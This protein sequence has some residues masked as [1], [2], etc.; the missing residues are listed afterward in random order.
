MKKL[1][2]F[3]I[4]FL[5]MGCASTQSE[6]WVSN[7]KI[8]DRYVGWWSPY[9]STAHNLHIDLNGMIESYISD[10]RIASEKEKR[11]PYFKIK[12]LAF[13][14]IPDGFLAL[15]KT[16]IYLPD[17]D[18]WSEETVNFFKFS[19]Q[20]N[21]TVRPQH[22]LTIEDTSCNNYCRS[23]GREYASWDTRMIR[24]CCPAAFDKH[25]NLLEGFSGLDAYAR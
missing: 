25:G 8:P 11:L 2:F 24:L 23:E 1:L 12:I 13:S 17:S 21:S 4:I 3:F 20:E 16:K 22:L 19:Y 9:S 10:R 5:L 7:L 14:L 6:V 15:G 18:K